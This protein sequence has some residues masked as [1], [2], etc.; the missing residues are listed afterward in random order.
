MIGQI[1][2]AQEF[3]QK[4]KATIQRTGKLGFT[5]ETISTLQLSAGTYVRIAPDTDN[6]NIYYIA[7]VNEQ[8]E[9]GFKVYSSGDYVNL[10]TKQLFDKIGLD[11]VKWNI[12]FDLNR[13]EDGD[14]PMGGVCYTMMMRKKERTS[15]DK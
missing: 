7:V 4:L 1:Y 2:N 9:D 15:D 11:Y 12:M 10:Q 14:A 5:A 13:F 3:T 6:K 8:I